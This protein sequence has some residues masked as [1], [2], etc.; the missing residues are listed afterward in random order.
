M[1]SSPS[2]VVCCFGMSSEQIQAM[3]LAYISVVALLPA[4]INLSW[5][6]WIKLIDTSPQQNTTKRCVCIFSRCARYSLQWRHH[7]RDGVSNHRHLGC[8]PST[9]CSRA[10]QRKHQS[11]LSL[12]FVRG[13]HRYATRS[14]STYC[15]WLFYDYQLK[16]LVTTKCPR[17]NCPKIMYTPSGPGV[18]LGPSLALSWRHMSV[19]VS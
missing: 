17:H 4:W 11:S 8:L 19:M 5:N 10:D 7:E 3:Y 15:H 1:K 9:V 18:R 6:I 13:I 14:E 2:V 16:A 12:A